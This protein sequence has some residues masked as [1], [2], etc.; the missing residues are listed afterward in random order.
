MQIINQKFKFKDVL[1]ISGL[2]I[3]FII[4]FAFLNLN[5]IKIN[6]SPKIF[7]WVW[8][9]PENLLFIDYKI[10]IAF[11]AGTITFYNSEVIFKPR[12]QPLAMSPKLSVMPV[13]RI[14]NEEKDNQL[15]N[16]QLSKAVELIVKI[17][18][19]DKVS[20]CQIDFDVK[21]SEID[22]YKNLILKTRNSLSKSIPLSITTLVSWCY[23]GSWLDNL[24]VDEAVPMFFRLGTDEYLIRQDL[25]GESFMKARNCQQAIGISVD[26]P[27]PQAK[28]LKNRRIYIFNPHSWTPEDF[29]NIIKELEGKLIE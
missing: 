27:L 29:S 22:F 20:G 16:N 18:S 5:Y 12:L 13:I 17:C 3:G 8:E 25:V 26:E 7:L 9:R 15:N 4:F 21:S 10:G 2:I 14:V 23:T 11:Y 1:L 28:Y 24:P 19:Q 6:H